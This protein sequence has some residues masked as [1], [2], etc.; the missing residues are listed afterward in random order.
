M[1]VQQDAAQ[2]AGAGGTGA[3]SDADVAGA[4]DLAAESSDAKGATD[5]GGAPSMRA[6][7]PPSSAESI[8]IE[9]ATAAASATT[10]PAPTRG[11]SL[12]QT[13]PAGASA[14]RGA[15]LK[16]EVVNANLRFVE[17]PV[18]VGHYRGSVLAGAE[19]VLDWLLGSAMST[20]IRLGRYPQEL[21]AQQIFVNAPVD[22]TNPLRD[23]PRPKGVV[24]AGLGDEGH[25][26][27]SGLATAVRLGVIA[28]A[29]HLAEAARTLDGTPPPPPFELA[30][31]LIGSG[32][33]GM[34]PGLA[35]RSVAEGVYEAN[36]LLKAA[37]WPQVEQLSLVELFLDRATEAWR[38]LQ[39]LSKTS[40]GCYEVRGYVRGGPGALLRPLDSS[41]RGADFDLFTASTQIDEDGGASIVYTLDTRRAR[42]EVRAVAAQGRLLQELV[43]VASSNT[44]NDDSIGRTLFK[45]LVP[46]EM[47]PFLDGASEMQ[48]ELDAGTAGIPWELL[49]SRRDADSAGGDHKPWAIR[50]KLLR[51][52]RTQEFR[53]QVDETGRRAPILL[54]GDPSSDDPRYPLLPGAR[55]EVR[56]V[57][58]LLQGSLGNTRGVTA[59]VGATDTERGPDARQIVV[60]LLDND[61]S[62]V[63]I[64]GHGQPAMDRAAAAA[65][66]ANRAVAAAAA[67]RGGGAFVG[68]AGAMNGAAFNG[69]ANAASGAALNGANGGGQGA[70]PYGSYGPYGPYSPYGGYGLQATPETA[71]RAGG[72]VLS[73]G[74]FLGADEFAKMQRVPELVF[75]N[76]CY[77]A[78]SDPGSL[79]NAE[80][81]PSIHRPYFAA[82]VADALIRIGVRC[83]VAAGWAVDDDAASK[84]ATS[85]YRALLDGRRFV[86]AVAVA[87]EAAWT[88][89]NNTWAAYQCY[90]D[91]DW[92]LHE[93]TGPDESQAD[94]HA[95]R[96]DDA[97]LAADYACIA[98]S[99]GLLIA[100]EQ[101]QTELRVNS[102]DVAASVRRLRFLH[103]NYATTPPYWGRMGAVAEAFAT[104]WK[105]AGSLEQ[106]VEFYRQAL[107]ANDCTATMY[108]AEQLIRSQ[109]RLALQRVRTA[110]ASGSAALLQP[111]VDAA[112]KLLCAALASLAQLV[113][114]FPT[115]DRLS[116]CGA[117]SKRLAMIERHAG[118]RDAEVA[119]IAQAM[120]HYQ[121]AE[122]AGV[123]SDNGDVYYVRINRCAA[124]LVSHLAAAQAGDYA[125]DWTRIVDALPE[126][127][128]A[129]PD[130]WSRAARSEVWIFQCVAERTLALNSA[131]IAL[132]LMQ[133]QRRLPAAAYWMSVYDHCDFVLSEYARR[134]E[135]PE[136]DA[137]RSLLANLEA[138]AAPVPVGGA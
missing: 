138:W 108:A 18:L 125:A 88:P 62:V 40:P 11:L 85:F 122:A 66:A 36:R 133:L 135:P 124:E 128:S 83:V 27:V 24:V 33:T 100:L 96:D 58:A 46:V 35:A 57:A 22:R 20:S 50:A 6:E 81:P 132:D 119:A 113:A 97:A 55:R 126:R 42:T 56:E 12:G 38:S 59:L 67:A 131:L 92:C 79:L 1:D 107:A 102:A 72:V 93:R 60:R 87:R 75:I 41:Y 3:E 28:W 127:V 103:R 116:L 30:A 117:V 137:A 89:A 115:M 44:G 123:A 53:R 98:S 17:E 71:S 110:S 86:D 51:K 90:G 105:E 52:L 15:P 48:L 106:A 69:G 114:M 78:R 120:G 4:A 64:A 9:T 134:A 14:D 16:V 45:L 29:Q 65:V 54:I 84:F 49:D 112:R 68:G 95:Q 8:E 25:L 39:L 21:K 34:T 13:R 47:R 43:S 94:E 104:A 99:H 130:F 32:G 91:P 63:H 76:C 37:G 10:L 7:A 31:T 109:V 2:S 82:S 5:V 136:A 70:G 111:A 23:V 61:W 26:R 129:E 19:A 80:P 121:A 101:I 74:T 118:C 73:N 77:L